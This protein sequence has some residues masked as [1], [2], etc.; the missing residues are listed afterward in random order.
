MKKN[1]I[2][3]IRLNDRLFITK[4]IQPVCIQTLLR[5]EH[6]QTNL[7]VAGW[8]VTDS[9]YIYTIKR[10]AFDSLLISINIR[11]SFLF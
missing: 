11:S 4:F 9:K 7:T 3:L 10:I 2:A 5:D 8:G 6:I 1:D